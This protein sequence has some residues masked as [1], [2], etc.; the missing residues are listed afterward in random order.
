MSDREL[1]HE[2]RRIEKMLRNVIRTLDRLEARV[3]ALEGGESGEGQP[4]PPPST[5]PRTTAINVR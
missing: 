4:P 5:Y 2:L 1:R 3:A